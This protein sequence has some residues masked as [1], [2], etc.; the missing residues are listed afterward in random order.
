MNLL[1]ERQ[2]EHT[3]Y[4]SECVTHLWGMCRECNYIGAYDAVISAKGPV[5]PRR[6]MYPLLKGDVRDVSEI[7]M[8][9]CAYNELVE[10]KA[11]CPHTNLSSLLGTRLI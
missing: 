10:L 11:L 8:T 1:R 2:V 6:M 5:H 3:H 9:H 4:D 7:T